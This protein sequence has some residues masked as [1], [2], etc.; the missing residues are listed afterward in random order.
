METHPDEQ[1]M[2]RAVSKA[3]LRTGLPLFTHTPHLK[4]NWG[5]GFS[6]VLVTF[7]GKMR[8]AGVN[9][10]TI[11]KILRENPRRFLAFAPKS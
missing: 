4:A 3:H 10:G 6:A 5:D 9:E 8:H 7:A 11:R 2:M 1:K